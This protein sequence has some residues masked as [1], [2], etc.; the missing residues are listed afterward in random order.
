M[1]TELGEFNCVTSSEELMPFYEPESYG[2]F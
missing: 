1:E 2:Q